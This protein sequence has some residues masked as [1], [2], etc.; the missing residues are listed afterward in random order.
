M[1]LE[2]AQIFGQHDCFMCHQE[3]MGASDRRLIERSAGEYVYL[4]VACYEKVRQLAHQHRV[5]LS[6]GLEL[7]SVQLAAALLGARA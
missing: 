1:S 2:T 6:E 7:Y 4:N 5:S 3:Y